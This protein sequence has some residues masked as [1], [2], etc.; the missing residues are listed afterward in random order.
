MSIK[1]SIKRKYTAT[2]L[3]QPVL[4][5]FGGNCTTDQTPDKISETRSES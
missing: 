2:K 5:E 3:E 4:L 1:P